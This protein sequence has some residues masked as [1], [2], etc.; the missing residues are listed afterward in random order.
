MPLSFRRSLPIAGAA[1]LM[2]AALA[3]AQTHATPAPRVRPE[4]SPI[5]DLL[6]DL[7]A[8]SPTARGLAAAVNDSDLIAYVRYRTFTTATLNGRIGFVRSQTPTRTLI[9]E[10]ACQRLWIDQLVTLGHELQ[11]AAEIAASTSVVD[12][13]SMARFFDRI[14]MRLSGP[15]EAE[16]FETARARQVSIHIRHEL[17]VNPGRTRTITHDR[18]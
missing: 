12:P 2:T 3:L 7:L 6:D 14:G 4:A 10:I 16:T 13:R 17:T 15:L 1:V 8:R 9:I 18:D 5:A 11:H